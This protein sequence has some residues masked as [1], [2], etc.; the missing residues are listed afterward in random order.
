MITHICNDLGD[1]NTWKNAL[2]K[3]SMQSSVVNPAG[4]RITIIVTLQVYAM[5]LGYPS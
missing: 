1:H 4:G 2:S 3:S 5:I